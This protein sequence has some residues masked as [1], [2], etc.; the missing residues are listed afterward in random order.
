MMLKEGERVKRKRG[1]PTEKEGIIALMI[2]RKREESTEKEK[3]KVWGR[4]K[5]KSNKKEALL[6]VQNTEIW[7]YE[8]MVHAQPNICPGEW[9]TQTPMVFWHTNRSPNL[10]QTSRPY[11]NQQLQKKKK[12]KKKN[13]QNCGLGCPSWPQSKIKETEKKDKYLD[14]TRE[15]KKQWNL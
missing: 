5:R 8:Q 2:R 10:S 12:Q 6:F 3:E 11:Y 13:S 7:P 9:D 4:K 15:L 14:L 1:E